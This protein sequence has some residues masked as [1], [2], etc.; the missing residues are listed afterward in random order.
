MPSQLTHER[1]EQLRDLRYHR[2]AELRV[3]SEQQALAFI[4]EVGFAFLF[5]DKG[6]EI[7]TLWAAICGRK[8]ELPHHSHFDADVGRTWTY[9]DTLPVRGEVYYG[10]LLR[11]KPTMVSLEVLPYFYALSPN[12]GELDDYLELY[13]DGKLSVDAKAVYLTLLEQGAMATTRLRQ[14]A[15]LPG[16]GDNARRFERA[17]AELQTNLMI[18][19]SGIADT[20]RWGYAY[21]YDLFLRRYP[22]VPERAREISSDC[23]MEMLLTRHLRNVIAQPESSLRRLFR[24]EPW[25]WERLLQRLQARGALQTVELEGTSQLMLPDEPI[26]AAEARPCPQPQRSARQ[27]ASDRAYPP[28]QS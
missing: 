18:V 25:E 27:R 13:A 20:N 14:L 19:K 28:P 5:G 9:K 11:G 24:W 1:I 15:G 12:Y 7:P 23:A 4:D 3:R 2:T 21:V 22:Q 16:G 8:R 6:V 26:P 10:K 17:I